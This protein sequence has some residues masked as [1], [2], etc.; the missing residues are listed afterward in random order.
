MLRYFLF[1]LLFSCSLATST[2]EYYHSFAEFSKFPTNISYGRATNQI[3]DLGHEKPNCTPSTIHDFPPDMFTQ[4]QRQQGGVVVHFILSIY[5][6]LMIG[7]VVDVYFV[8]S[9][10]IIGKGIEYTLMNIYT[11]VL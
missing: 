7:I 11:Q 3:S 5:T 1:M 6:M 4:Q 9:L 2:N 8:P 10:E